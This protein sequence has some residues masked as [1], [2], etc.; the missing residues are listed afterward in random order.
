MQPNSIFEEKDWFLVWNWIQL[1]SSQASGLTWIHL[2]RA[3]KRGCGLNPLLPNKSMM[4]LYLL[5]SGSCT[6]WFIYVL[7][8]RARMQFVYIHD[9]GSW[10]CYCWTESRWPH[11]ESNTRAARTVQQELHVSGWCRCLP[12]QLNLS[13]QAVNLCK[14]LIFFEIQ[15]WVTLPH[16]VA[17]LGA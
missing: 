8:M 17:W 7:G 4:Q 14:I 2:I 6:Y 3:W 1:E 16:K 12:A 11:T 10:G 9:S 13:S 5:A 15:S